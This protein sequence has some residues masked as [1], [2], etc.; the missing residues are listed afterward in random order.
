MAKQAAVRALSIRL[1]PGVWTSRVNLL[2]Y[3]SPF[4]QELPDGY[5][6]LPGPRV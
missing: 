3:R 1:N 6:R 4:A 2:R 5:H